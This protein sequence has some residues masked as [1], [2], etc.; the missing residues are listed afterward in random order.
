MREAA[1]EA[2]YGHGAAA[3]STVRHRER[4]AIQALVAAQGRSA[5]ADS[6][7]NRG[8]QTQ[9]AIASIIPEQDTAVSLVKSSQPVKHRQSHLV[10]PPGQSIAGSRARWPRWRLPHRGC[11]PGNVGMRTWTGW[12][13]TATVTAQQYPNGEGLRLMSLQSSLQRRALAT[14]LGALS[15]YNNILCNWEH[16]CPRQLGILASLIRPTTG[17]LISRPCEV[18]SRVLG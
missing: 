6:Q 3:T 10:D 9:Y 12:P 13:H 15:Y 18:P 11:L 14:D 7:F 2:G 4:C 1:P 8:S 17:R 5:E 16:S